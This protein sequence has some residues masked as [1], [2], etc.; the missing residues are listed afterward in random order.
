[1]PCASLQTRTLLFEKPSV[2]CKTPGKQ[3][4]GRILA[5]DFLA[6]RSFSL[7]QFSGSVRSAL[8]KLVAWL[9]AHRSHFVLQHLGENNGSRSI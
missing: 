3:S 6:A 7:S 2:L 8:E 5:L 9:G 1:M 4:P